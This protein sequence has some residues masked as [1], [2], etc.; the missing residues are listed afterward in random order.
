MGRSTSRKGRGAASI[1]L[2]VASCLLLLATVGETFVSA[3][4]S[5]QVS[6]SSTWEVKTA[7]PVNRHG[8]LGTP[9]TQASLVKAAASVALLCVAATK[10][11]SKNK[12][13]KSSVRCVV[14]MTAPSTVTSTI[15]A[16]PK[17][18]QM[19]DL[20]KF[21]DQPAIEVPVV[22]SATVPCAVPVESE[23]PAP[24][25]GALRAARFAAGARRNG[26]RGARTSS[27]A[28]RSARSARRAVG[29]RLCLSAFAVQPMPFESFD[30]SKT[31]GKIQL[32][33]RVSSCMRSESGRESKVSSGVDG[34]EMGTCLNFVA[35]DLKVYMLDH[36]SALNDAIHSRFGNLAQSAKL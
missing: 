33:L 6:P 36:E 25:C 31:R 30:A 14:G 35:H 5:F 29:Q 2:L 11:V 26:S 15:S 28:A 27:G 18:L 22:I 17:S 16:P 7:Q 8:G 19:E 21:E 4:P 23:A 24:F 1:A 10:C 9:N 20:L 13:P 3:S 34:S 32:G 12:T